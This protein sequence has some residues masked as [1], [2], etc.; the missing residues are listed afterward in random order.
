M[1]VV[2]KLRD[3]DFEPKH[4]EAAMRRWKK[5]F[6]FSRKPC[7]RA[8]LQDLEIQLLQ[9]QI[10]DDRS[11]ISNKKDEGDAKDKDI[12]VGSSGKLLPQQNSDDASSVSDIKDEGCSSRKF[13]PQNSDA[14]SHM[15]D[16]KGKG[17]TEDKGSKGDSSQML[18]P[19]LNLSGRS[20]ISE[21]KEEG[22]TEDKGFK[23]GSSRMM[24]PQLNSVGRSNISDIKEEVRV[25]IEDQ[26][27]EGSSCRMLLTQ[28]NSDD[29]SNIGDQQVEGAIEDNGNEGDT[30]DN[31]NDVGTCGKVWIFLVANLGIELL[32]AIFD[33]LASVHKPTFALV[34]MLLAFVGLLGFIME[35][36]SKGANEREHWIWDMGICTRIRTFADIF[37]LLSAMLQSISAAVAYAYYSHHD[38]P[39]K[40]NLMSVVFAF[41][42]L[43]SQLLKDLSP[44]LA[45]PADEEAPIIPSQ[46][47]TD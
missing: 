18:L 8:V 23:G 40:L 13:S 31:G 15:I 6:S 3:F 14:C 32:S 36:A 38:K 22:D 34:A 47:I 1:G 17:D 35:I 42:L 20:N 7:W 37:G 33:Q 12:E 30:E 21:I 9:S 27:S 45:A 2:V 28:Q 11:K 44:K 4:S 43:C 16:I 29:H 39:N 5:L 25:D 41:C 46:H 24:L 26:G 10:S 19:L